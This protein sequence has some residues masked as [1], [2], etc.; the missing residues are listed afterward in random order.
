MLHFDSLSFWE[1]STLLEDI[2]FLVIGGGIVGI[3]TALSLREKHTSAKIM[4][5]ERGYLPTG[6]STKNAGF[7]CFGSVTELLDDLNSTEEQTV[8]E[9]VALRYE[10]L[11]R[12]LERFSPEKIGYQ[13]SGSFD[14]ITQN[15]KHQLPAYTDQLAYLNENIQRIT[16]KTDCYNWHSGLNEQF[17]MQGIVGGFHNRL[18]GEIHT[19]KLLKESYQLLQQASIICLY[20]ITVKAIEDHHDHTI[21]DTN[22]GTI[23]SKKTAVTV[24]GFAQ[25]LLK[26]D[27][28]LPARAQVVVTSPIPNLKLKGTF[29]YDKGYYYFRTIENRVLFGGGRNLNFQGETTT[30]F[31]QTEQIQ[32]ELERLLSEV[33]LPN[34]SFSIDYRWS[35]I[36]GV[37]SEKKPIIESYSPNIAIGVRMGGMGVAIGSIVGEKV[38]EIL[39]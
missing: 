22:Y 34:K 23:K 8:W 27:R 28:I 9:T 33:I 30:N 16:G 18:E 24:N 2:D 20:G 5:I 17:E 3:S 29:H 32:G 7:T 4:L 35:G 39:S 10:G 14:L 26:D 6:A 11:Q 21:V 12:L 31:G 15:E 13:N 37:G 1:K 19:G 38:A 36:M 25:E